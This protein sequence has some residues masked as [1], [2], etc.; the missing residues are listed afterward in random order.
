MG[1]NDKQRKKMEV[2]LKDTPNRVTEYGSGRASSLTDELLGKIE[3]I[4]GTGIL[5][6]YVYKQL[7]IPEGTWEYW[8]SQGKAF[9]SRIQDEDDNM[10][11]EDLPVNHKRWVYLLA[12]IDSS[13]AKVVTRTWQNM[14]DLSKTNFKA[15]EFILRTLGKNDFH[16]AEVFVNHN[17]GIGGDEDKI[18]QKELEGFLPKNKEDLEGNEE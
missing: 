5:Q 8:K 15:G 11:W 1:L 7:H 16:H 9:L 17:I 2:F 14:S 13:K 3:T 18:I 6:K 10:V 4:M 12:I